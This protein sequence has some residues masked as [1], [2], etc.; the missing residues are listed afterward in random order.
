[1]RRRIGGSSWREMRETSLPKS[2]ISPRVGFSERKSSRSSVVLPA[3]EGP[4]RNWNDRG[5]IGR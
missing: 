1:M 4:V 3:P 5:S 2:V